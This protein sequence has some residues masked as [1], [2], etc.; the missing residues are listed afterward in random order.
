MTG[1]VDPGEEQHE[2]GSHPGLALNRDGAFA[3]LDDAHHHGQS[4]TGSFILAFGGEIGVEN[5]L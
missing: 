3:V 2:T 4:E 5:A 1:V